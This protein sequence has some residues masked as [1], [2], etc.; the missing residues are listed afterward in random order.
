MAAGSDQESAKSAGT[1]KV[2]GE[3]P[4]VQFPEA[5]ALH[6]LALND[7][8]FVFDP[9]TGNSFSVNATGLAVIRA[10]LRDEQLEGIVE[11]L[12]RDFE[13]DPVTA[14]R[15]VLEFSAALRACFQ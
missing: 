10:L 13:V 5:E 2:R 14:E 7:S 15:E 6:R 8:G 12:T 3:A 9:V 4:S 11:S 1:A